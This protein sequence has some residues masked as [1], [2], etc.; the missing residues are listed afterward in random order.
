MR[1]TAFLGLA[2]AALLTAASAHA[3]PEGWYTLGSY[4]CHANHT[5][6]GTDVPPLR[7]A[8]S[9]G[10]GDIRQCQVLC[11]ETSG[12]VA[13]SFQKRVTER[14]TIVNSCIL[15]GRYDVDTVP[16]S[17][18]GPFDWGVVCYRHRDVW[19]KLPSEWR[20]R[21]GLEQDQLRPGLRP[22]LPSGANK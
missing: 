3:L 15:Y 4:K 8:K 5:A 19:D 2:A 14:G 9:G 10:A 17:D 21:L 20:S 18:S 7:A 13:F 6:Y 22:S 16:I 12:C 11:E 1:K